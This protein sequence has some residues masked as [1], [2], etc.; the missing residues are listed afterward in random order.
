MVRRRILPIVSLLVFLG[1]VF[2]FLLFINSHLEENKNCALWQV[3]INSQS[4]KN[5]FSLTDNNP[6]KT[7]EEKIFFASNSNNSNTRNENNNKKEN[8]DKTQC[9][10]KTSCQAKVIYVIDGDTIYLATGEKVRYV[11]IN[12]PEIHHPYKKVECF[13]KEAS[14]ENKNLVEGKNVILIKDISDKDKY[15]RLLRYVYAD[16]I[17]VNDFLVKNG[18][19]LVSTF[20]PDVENKNLFLESENYARKNYLGLWSQSTCAGKK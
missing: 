13:G 6:T 20:P 5:N 7:P 12:A 16:D 2:F 17:F 9:S 1:V 8:I 18:Y 10:G 4:C 19:A 11:G 15:G 3:L 14:Q